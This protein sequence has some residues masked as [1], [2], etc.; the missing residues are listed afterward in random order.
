MELLLTIIVCVMAAGF[1]VLVWQFV[2]TKGRYS[3]YQ[4]DC[5]LEGIQPVSFEEFNLLET[6]YGRY[7]SYRG[8]K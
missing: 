4:I 6:R 7:I 3:Q 8:R 1:A 2:A 5:I